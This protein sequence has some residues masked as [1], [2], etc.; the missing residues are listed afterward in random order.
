MVRARG[1]AVGRSPTGPTA[2]GLGLS[3]R[4][5]VVA[6]SVVLATSCRAD[7]PKAGPPLP[8]GPPVVVVTMREYRYEYPP[9]VPAGRVVFRFVNAGQSSHRPSLLPLPE[10]VPPI[11]VQLRGS[12]RR[13]ATPFAGVPTRKPG[14]QGTF[15]VDL[16]PGRRYALICF[17]KDADGQSHSLKGMSSEF[18]AG[19][20]PKP[21]P[22]TRPE[23]RGR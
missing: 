6:A 2:G 22:P 13:V 4:A 3:A 17:A 23:D 9:V 19:G 14:T 18:R 16:V 5:V 12:E 21:P 15:A 8:K 20:E 10:D 7:S 11:D 1:S